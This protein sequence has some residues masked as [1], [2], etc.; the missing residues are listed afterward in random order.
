MRRVS[1]TVKQSSTG[2][3]Y[4][5]Q[6]MSRYTATLVRLHLP[7][8]AADDFA[9]TAWTEGN[10]DVLRLVGINNEY[11]FSCRLPL[12]QVLMSFGRGTLH[13]PQ[14]SVKVDLY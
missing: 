8:D 5:F 9:E 1:A 12:G 2:T 14:D 10:A 4:T 13:L 6:Q 11:C 3:P 7:T